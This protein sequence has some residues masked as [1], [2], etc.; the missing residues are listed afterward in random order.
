MKLRLEQLEARLQ[1]LVEDQLVGILPGLKLEDRV[2]Q[3]LA[4][5]VKENIVQQKEDSPLAPNVYTLIVA[6]DTSPM[7]KEQRTINTLKNIIVTAG[8]DVGLGFVGQPI[9]TITTDDTYSAEEVRVVASHKL[10]PV[11][12]TQG[13]QN[14]PS[15]ESEEN[16]GIPENAFLIIEGVKVH[17]LNE[18]VVNIGRRLENQLVIDDPRVS[19][20]HAQLR[21]IKGRFVL[22]DLNSTGGTFVNGQRTSQTVL[23]PGDVISLAGVALI[24]GQDNPP[25]RPD[26][27]NTSPMDVEPGRSERP[28]AVLNNQNTVDL[29][30]GKT[31][32]TDEDSSN[33]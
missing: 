9:I 23:Y 31:K 11:G 15:G 19:R 25:P 20:N 26:V 18:S 21:A 10:E 3:H 1:K 29:K 8:K 5:A 30:P 14:T 4:T 24:F 32:N 33:P 27:S 2:I 6:T 13:I 12:E 28:T 7:W 22:F 17:P 16:A